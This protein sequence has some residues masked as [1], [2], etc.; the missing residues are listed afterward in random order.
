MGSAAGIHI[1]A[2]TGALRSRRLLRL[3]GDDRVVAQIRRG[4]E[5]AFE[6][7]FERHGPAI[8]GFCRHMLGSLEEA[9]DAVQLTFASA[10]RDLQRDAERQINL[11]PWLFTIARNRCLSILRARREQ[12]AELPELATAGLGEQVER[13]AELRELVADMRDLPGDQRAALLLAELGDLTHADIAMVLGCEVPHVKA[14]VYRARSGLLARRD[15][16][17]LDCE[18]VR[19]QLANLRGGALRRRE[20]R[21]HLRECPGCSS[22]REQVKRQRHL[23][24]AGLPVVPGVGLKSSVLATVGIGGGAAGA[25]GGAAAGGGLLGGSA[26]AKL[27]IAGVMAT[28]GTAALVEL[29]ARQAAPEPAG[30][31]GVT[32]GAGGGGPA[33][34]FEGARPGTP[35]ES[36]SVAAGRGHGP[37]ALERSDPQDGRARHGNPHGEATGQAGPK[38]GGTVARGRGPVEAPPASTPVRRGPPES[39]RQP[40]KPAPKLKTKPAPPAVVPDR[41]E[42]APQQSKADKA[43]PR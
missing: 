28:G 11:K 12:P 22:F 18:D 29:E 21:F 26:V 3:A 32:R 6:V 14:L 40:A 37:R 30:G 39:K 33:P 10:Y 1:P 9:E 23:L 38:G 17:E 16:R 19:E 42:R 13:R 34:A 20:L 35:A 7:V 8:L 31:A 24:A 43:E 4:S 25:V 27:A 36:G 5:A 2:S 15:G 41:P